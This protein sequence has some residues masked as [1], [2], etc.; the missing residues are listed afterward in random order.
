M[1]VFWEKR[2]MAISS[3]IKY[4][5]KCAIQAHFLFRDFWHNTTSESLLTQLVNFVLGGFWAKLETP[6]E[7]LLKPHPLSLS[8]IRKKVSLYCAFTCII[9]NDIKP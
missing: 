9:I 8:Y 2:R 4:T 3:L 5:G 6:S 1:F 7:C